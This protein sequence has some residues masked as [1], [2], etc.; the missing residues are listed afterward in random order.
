MNAPGRMNINDNVWVRLTPLGRHIDR[1]AHEDLRAHFPSIGPYKPAETNG[2]SKWQLWQLMSRFGLH[3]YVGCEPPFDT[4]ISLVDPNAPTPRAMRWDDIAP[5][6]KCADCP[7]V[8]GDACQRD[9][10]FPDCTGY[11]DWAFQ[12][13]Y[14]EAFK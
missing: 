11:S 14:P 7:H 3:C 8:V 1:A 13:E 5:T 10:C 6:R 12:I 2:W 4:E 9:C